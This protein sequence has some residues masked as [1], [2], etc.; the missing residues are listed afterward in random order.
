MSTKPGSMPVL[1]LRI[2]TTAQ[3]INKPAFLP[4]QKDC[5]SC[6]IG[7]SNTTVTMFAWNLPA[8]IART[9]GAHNKSFVSRRKALA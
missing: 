1:V 8:S 6:V 5:K 7:F 9:Y 2:P 4:L 3:S